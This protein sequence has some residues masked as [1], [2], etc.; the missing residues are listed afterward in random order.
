MSFKCRG[1]ETSDAFMMSVN[2][3]Y[4]SSSPHLLAKKQQQLT[5]QLFP[6]TCTHSD[7]PAAQTHTRFGLK[8]LECTSGSHDVYGN[9]FYITL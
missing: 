3:R 5:S 6:N 7:T 2:V 8:W 4:S 9:A 1:E